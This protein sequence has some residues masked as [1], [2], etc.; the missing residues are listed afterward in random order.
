MVFHGQVVVGHRRVVVGIIKVEVVT[1][2]NVEVEEVDEVEVEVVEVDVVDVEE[3]LVV[4]E[5]VDEVEVVVV[6]VGRGMTLIGTALE[7][8]LL[9][10]GGRITATVYSPFMSDMGK[11]KERSVGETIIGV[12]VTIRPFDKAVMRTKE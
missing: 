9:S 7:I 4:V 12:A 3:V 8:L 2:I 10:P 5:V 6:V 11:W 1:G